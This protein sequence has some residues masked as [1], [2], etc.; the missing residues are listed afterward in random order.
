MNFRFQNS[1]F[2]ISAEENRPATVAT[3]EQALALC[4]GIRFEPGC[5]P[6]AIGAVT[7][8]R[9]AQLVFGIGKTRGPGAIGHA[10]SAQARP[11]SLPGER[12]QTAKRGTESSR[13][14]AVFGKPRFWP[15][16]VGSCTVR[17]VTH[18]G[19]SHF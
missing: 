13:Q 10:T 8:V 3:G 4:A 6:E 9:R 18:L 16:R 19:M 5:G 1:D 15:G 14:K 2:R 12:G 11:G 7:F 17:S